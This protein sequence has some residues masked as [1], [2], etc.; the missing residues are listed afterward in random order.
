MDKEIWK[1]FKDTRSNSI[2][3]TRGVLWEVSNQGQVKKNGILYECKLDKK[4]YKIFGPN[5]SVH[6]A[7]AQLFILNPENKP[8][9]DHINTD[10][11]D[12]RVCNLRWCTYKENNNNPITKRKM[13][14]ARKLYWAN[15][16]ITI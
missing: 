14:E 4:G 3:N 5:Y 6:K 10:K 15:K 12:N 9:V 13:S 1:V 2:K 16:K 7:V 8:C 11:L